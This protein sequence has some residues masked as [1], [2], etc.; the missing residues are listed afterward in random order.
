MKTSAV[1]FEVDEA[2]ATI[3]LNDGDRM[4]PLGDEVIDG[5]TDAVGRVRDDKRVRAL[6]LTGRGRGFCVGADLAHYRRL[7]DQPEAG[8]TLGQYVGGLMERM[9]P[10]VQALK[11]LPVPVVCAING[12]AAGGGAGLALSGDLVVAAKSSYF[13]LPFFPSLGAVPD[14]GATWALPRAIGRARA[15]GLALTGEKL[16]AQKAQEWGLIWACVEDDRLE[17]E[18]RRL[19]RQLAA[20]PS[21]AILEARAIFAA[22]ERNTLPQQLALERARQMELLDGQSFAEGVRAFAERRAPVFPGR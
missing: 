19:A 18:S 20:M 11:E 7:I 12:V 9:N 6:I 21:H 1:L 2:I 13:Y 17:A 8:R 22:A 3:S 16:P 4:N 15:L 10:V 14:M 5:M